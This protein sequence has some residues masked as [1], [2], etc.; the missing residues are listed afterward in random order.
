M[1]VCCVTTNACFM[2]TPSNKALQMD[3]HDSRFVTLWPTDLFLVWKYKL[4]SGFFGGAT[5]L[6]I[7][8]STICCLLLGYGRAFGSRDAAINRLYY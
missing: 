8:I 1:S 4:G 6:L 3:P 7:Y 5:T 2:T